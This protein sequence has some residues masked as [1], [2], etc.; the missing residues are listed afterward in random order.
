MGARA[1]RP[2]PGAYTAHAAIFMRSPFLPLVAGRGEWEQQAKAGVLSRSRRRVVLGL[3]LAGR[4]RAMIAPRKRGGRGG[5]GRGRKGR[6]CILLLSS[7]PPLPPTR[8]SL[9]AAVRC[10][11]AVATELPPPRFGAGAASWCP[12][13]KADGYPCAAPASNTPPHWARDT[14]HLCVCRLSGLEPGFPSVDGDTT[15][16][17]FGGEFGF[18]LFDSLLSLCIT[19]SV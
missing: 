17:H 15:P 11:G 13:K 18:R 7:P 12:C 8:S 19:P 9:E 2:G 16:P 6:V 5:E 14:P 3:G 10:A 4:H 1:G